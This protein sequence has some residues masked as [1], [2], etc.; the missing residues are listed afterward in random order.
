MKS[1]LEI[2]VESAERMRRALLHIIGDQHPPEVDAY[3]RVREMAAEALGYPSPEPWP[4]YRLDSHE[5][6]A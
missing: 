2:L 5:P 1:D 3:Q 6:A 4:Q